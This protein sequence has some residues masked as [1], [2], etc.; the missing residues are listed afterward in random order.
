MTI[1]GWILFI[2]III[3]IAIV[4]VFIIADSAGASSEIALVIT[5]SLFIIIAT[6]FGMLWFFNNT[7]SG[8]RAMIDQKSDLNNGLERIVTVYTANGDVIAK[9]EG[10]I[11]IED[12][13]GGYVI[14]DFNGKRYMYYNCF[15]ESIADIGD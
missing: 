5:I 7:A 11:D 14:F 12:N 4:D 15:V 10:K 13:D 9:Y 6:L 3:M 2:F 8:Q 1:G